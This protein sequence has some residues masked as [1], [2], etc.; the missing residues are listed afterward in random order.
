LV[1][2]A[3]DDVLAFWGEVSGKGFPVSDP[4]GV[5]IKGVGGFGYEVEIYSGLEMTDDH[6]QG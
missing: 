4:D 3:G 1:E 2:E 5:F 6:D